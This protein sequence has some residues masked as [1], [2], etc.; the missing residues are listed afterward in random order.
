MI[1]MG[2]LRRMHDFSKALKLVLE[3]DA[4]KHIQRSPSLA[5]ISCKISLLFSKEELAEKAATQIRPFS[6]REANFIAIFK[7]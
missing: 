4:R 5:S 7:V 3:L 6:F 1:E 2:L